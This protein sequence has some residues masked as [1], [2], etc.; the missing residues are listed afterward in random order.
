MVQPLCGSSDLF[1]DVEEL[2]SLNE[3]KRASNDY[4]Y[5][6]IPIVDYNYYIIPEQVTTITTISY[7]FIKYKT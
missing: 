5:Y 4:N 2:Q 6:I 7:Q 3:H 1:N